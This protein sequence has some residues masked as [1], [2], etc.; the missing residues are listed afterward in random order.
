MFTDASHAHTESIFRVEEQLWQP[1][2]KKKVFDSWLRF[3]S[4]NVKKES[5]CSTETSINFNPA[6][7]LHIQQ[8]KTHQNC[9]KHLKENGY[10]S[11]LWRIVFITSRH[12]TST[13]NRIMLSF[14]TPYIEKVN[15]FCAIQLFFFFQ[16]I[17]IFF[18]KMWVYIV[19][20]YIKTYSEGNKRLPYTSIHAF[21]DLKQ[22]T[23]A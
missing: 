21:P 8:A 15:L 3:Y 22:L 16:V 19:R 6:T 5:V 13:D 14:Y 11:M 17:N 18:A 23:D 4:Y 7:G 20:V 10:K 1:S 2:R 9:L 12:Q